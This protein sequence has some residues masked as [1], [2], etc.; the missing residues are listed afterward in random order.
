M[1]IATLIAGATLVAAIATPA[2]AQR[3]RHYY[4][5]PVY[6]APYYR[7]APAPRY[8]QRLC[9]YDRSPCDPIQFKVADGRCSGVYTRP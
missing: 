1:R 9:E 4:D 2:S 6:G 7:S 5:E 3:W 8:C